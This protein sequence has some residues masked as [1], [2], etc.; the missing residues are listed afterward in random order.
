MTTLGTR[1]KTWLTGQL[2]GKDQF[3]NRYYRSRRGARYGREQRWVIYEGEVEASRV[4]PAWHAWLHHLAAEAPLGER[5]RW[6]WQKEHQPNLTGTPDAYRPPGSVLE[7][8]HRDRA[9][10]DYEPW[11]PT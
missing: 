5:H 3:G 8:G 7:G 11:T 9:T 4:P 6:A 2:V 10:G 1:L